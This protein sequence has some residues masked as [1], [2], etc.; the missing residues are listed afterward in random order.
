[1]ADRA[2]DHELCAQ[3]GVF[4]LQSGRKAWGVVGS[5]IGGFRGLP[6]DSGTV[7][8]LDQRGR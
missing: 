1:M 7:N 5:P 3:A 4:L 8:A 6:I 2:F